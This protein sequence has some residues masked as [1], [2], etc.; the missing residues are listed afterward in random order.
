LFS[1]PFT[2]SFIVVW[3]CCCCVFVCVCVCA[4]V[5][6]GP[7]SFY[8]QRRWLLFAVV[9]VFLNKINFFE[10][11]TGREKRKNGGTYVFSPRLLSLHVSAWAVAAFAPPPHAPQRSK[12]RL[13]FLCNIWWR[14]AAAGCTTSF[15][16]VGIFFFVCLFMR[17]WVCGCC[18]THSCVYAK[19]HHCEDVASLAPRSSCVFA[20]FSHVA[21]IPS[22]PPPFPLPFNLPY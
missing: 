10:T 5:V 22:L 6:Q 21:I 19:L 18:L 14:V 12:R 11:L 17:V 9:V 20:L 7:L 16:G 3:C 15:I 4:C 8:L 1:L 13:L 2:F